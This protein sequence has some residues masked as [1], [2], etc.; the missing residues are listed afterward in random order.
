M[1]CTAI[2]FI[3]MVEG[4]TLESQF[5][6]NE[7]ADL[8]H[9]VGHASTPPDDPALKLSLLN[10]IT[11]MGNSQNTYESAR[12]NIQQCYLDI[13]LLSYYQAKR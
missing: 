4:A 6:P 11:F 1:F 10:F 3:D 8:H 5:D 13:E 7:L 12:Q 2:D 9:P